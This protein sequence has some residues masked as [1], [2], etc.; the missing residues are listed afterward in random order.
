MVDVATETVTE[1]AVERPGAAPTVPRVGEPGQPGLPGQPGQP[2]LP[3][4][5]RIF[6]ASQRQLVWWRFRK[7]KPALV[8]AVVVVLAYLVALFVEPLAPYP[9]DYTST[10][11]QYA[12][13]QAVHL[14]DQGRFVGPYAFGLKQQLDSAALRRVFVVDRE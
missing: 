10:L 14:F 8:S 7:H 4:E 3:D 11:H 2:G 13:P 1:I 12:P 5:P 9:T 6:V